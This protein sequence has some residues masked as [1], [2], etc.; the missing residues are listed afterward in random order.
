MRAHKVKEAKEVDENP[1]L[2]SGALHMV[3]PGLPAVSNSSI[4]MF[5]ELTT[6]KVLV[7][8]SKDPYRRQEASTVGTPGSN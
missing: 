3:A 1:D 7:Q 4:S 6:G 8:Q 2:V 5:I